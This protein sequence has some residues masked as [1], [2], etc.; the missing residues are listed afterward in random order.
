MGSII[1]TQ[2]YDAFNPILLVAAIYLVLV[3][4]LTKLLSVFERRFKKSDRS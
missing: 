3:L 2:T 4:G 1:Q